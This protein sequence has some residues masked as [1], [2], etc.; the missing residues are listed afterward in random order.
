M[1]TTSNKL[2]CFKRDIIPI[3]DAKI[4]IMTTTAQYGINVFEGVRCY[5]DE[6]EAK[7]F[8]FRLN[9]H[10]E[11]LFNSAKLMRFDLPSYL[12]R[13]YLVDKTK[14][15][16]IANNYNEDL[17]VK[18]GLFLDGVGSWSGAGPISEF[19]I[20]SPKGRV[21][22]DKVGVNCCVVSWGRISELDVPPRIKAGANYIN[23]RFAHLEAVRNNYDLAILMGQNGKI[24]E[25]TGACI[26]IV[27]NGNVITP[28][29]TNSILESIT[30]DTIISFLKD[31]LHIKVCER[32]VDRTE[33]YLS[34]EMFFAGTSVEILPIVSV[35]KIAIN[36]YL[37][38]PITKVIMEK[39]FEIARGNNKKFNDWLTAI[40]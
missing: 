36:N 5:Y 6:Q 28:P 19:I 24:A 10:I 8:A 18:I 32:E 40:N 11:R 2:I 15:I 33:L 21:F 1:N 37:V 17:Y 31:D 20:S 14:R 23:S 16:I 9:E 29:V 7:F 26:F 35:D 38:G 22:T 34:E 25:G 12:T 39:Y 3:D 27:K 30:R 13:E 4:N